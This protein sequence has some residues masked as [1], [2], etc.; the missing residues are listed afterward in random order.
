[1][2]APMSRGE[3]SIIWSDASAAT[4]CSW[5]ST[6]IPYGEDFRRRINE[7]LDRH[8]PAARDHRRPCGSTRNGRTLPRSARRL[9]DPNDYVG[10]EI[11]EALKRNI[12][13]LPVLVGDRDGRRGP[14]SC[15]PHLAELLDRNAAE[16]RTGRDFPAARQ[17]S[18]RRRSQTCSCCRRLERGRSKAAPSAAAPAPLVCAPLERDPNHLAGVQLGAFVVERLLAAGGSGMAYPRER[19]PRTGQ[20]VCVKVSLPVLSNMEGIRAA[21]ARGVRGLVA[22]NHPH[23]VRVHEFD[24]LDLTDARLFYVVMDYVDGELLDTWAGSLTRDSAGGPGAASGRVPDCPKRSRPRMPAATSMTQALRPSASCTATSSPG[25]SWCG[26]TARRRC[27][28]FMMVDVQRALDPVARERLASSA[29]NQ[30][31]VFGTPGF[32]APE[33]E[34]DGVV[35]IRTDIYGLGATLRAAAGQLPMPTGFVSLVDR[36]TGPVTSRPP[37]MGE[38]AR[39]LSELAG[40]KKARRTPRRGWNSR[41]GRKPGRDSSLDSS[42]CS[43]SGGSR[44]LD[45]GRAGY[46]GASAISRPP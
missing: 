41:K 21:V 46:R 15:L 3:S 22:L 34:R 9:D 10:V 20:R 25:T 1:M 39:L 37:H 24:A 7:A 13:V 26:L 36:M 6:A 14:G 44:A 32:M 18:D 29:D 31:A 35:T 40:D 17:P 5:M 8:R 38:V 2:T 11:S 33:Q 27:S 16:V 23:I 43:P 45:L 42:R 4:V 12:T 28:D 30:T 19:N